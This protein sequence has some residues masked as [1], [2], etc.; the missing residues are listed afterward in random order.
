MFEEAGP[1]KEKQPLDKL[2][3]A[4]LQMELAA[5][6]IVH[7]SA[8]GAQVYDKLMDIQKFIETGERA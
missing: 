4:L 5:N 8:R 1:P 7:A 6:Q 3:M 2:E